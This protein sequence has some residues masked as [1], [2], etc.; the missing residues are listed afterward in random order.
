MAGSCC[1]KRNSWKKTATGFKLSTDSV[2]C[3]TLHE[4]AIQHLW[5]SPNDD[6]GGATRFSESISNPFGM[7][8][9][10]TK[11]PNIS[12]EMI[13]VP[14]G[15]V[16]TFADNENITCV[17]CQ[18]NPARVVYEGKVTSLSESA[19]RASKL[20]YQRPE[21]RFTGNMKGKRFRS[22]E[23]RYRGVPLWR[24]RIGT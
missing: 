17:V 12:L 8:D 13:G 21:G 23:Y 24:K 11:K 5:A 6:V 22:A 14:L 4:L 3:S 20:E 7:K 18:Q 16:L 9:M 15:A 10:S 2:N 1:S 19:R